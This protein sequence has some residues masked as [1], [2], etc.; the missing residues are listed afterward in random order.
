MPTNKLCAVI[1]C[2]GSGTRFWPG[3]RQSLPKQFLKL[4]S[5]ASLIQET[6]SRLEGLV[7]QERVFLLAAANHKDNLRRHLPDIPETNFILEPSARNTAPALALAAKRIEAMGDDYIMAALPADHAI[8]DEK[9]FRDTLKTACEYAASSPGVVTIGIK[10][11]R[12]ETGYGYIE[13]G[14]QIQKNVNEVI[15]FVEKPELPKAEEYL[16]SKRYVW[17]GGIFVVR[18]NVLINGLKKHAAKIYKP[19]WEQLP[20]WGDANFPTKLDDIYNKLPKVSI[21]YALM[22][23]AENTACVS[24]GFDWNDLGSWN[25]LEAYWGKDSEGNASDGNYFSIDSA[26]NIVSTGGREVAL[27]GV[28]NLIVVERND[29]VM[30]CAKDR[31]Q[32]VKK[33]VELLEKEGRDDLL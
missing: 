29:V 32:D 11:T 26:G 22:E 19:M 30:I 23:E 25:A 12:P 18:V 13:L 17:N 27:I 15:Q 14:E 6:V 3:S 9:G 10:P 20:G 24:A 2:G 33:M 28:E 1:M 5:D 31:S 21:D 8:K 4:K 16:A 7:P